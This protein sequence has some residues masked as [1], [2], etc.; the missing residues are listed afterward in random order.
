MILFRKRSNLGKF[1]SI[2]QHEKNKI[3]SHHELIKKIITGLEE[4]LK[5]F[6]SLLV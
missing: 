4:V 2:M 5:H 6:T 1:T 3:Q